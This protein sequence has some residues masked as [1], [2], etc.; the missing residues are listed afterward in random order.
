MDYTSIFTYNFANINLAQGT[1]ISSLLGIGI[2]I[3]L[4]F[5]LYIFSL[6]IWC[7]LQYFKEKQNRKNKTKV[8][9]NLVLMKDI[10]TEIEKEIEQARLKAAFQD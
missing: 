6:L 1:F 2:S 9:K 3:V 7:L 4:I 8:L 10:Q 5:I